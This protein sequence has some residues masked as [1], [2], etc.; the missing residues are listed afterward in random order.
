[1]VFPR[2]SAFLL[3]CL[4]VQIIWDGV[5]DLLMTLFIYWVALRGAVPIVLALFPLMAG[6]P[7]AGPAM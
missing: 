2:L 1:M 6:T 3:L 5:R 4:G 7:Q